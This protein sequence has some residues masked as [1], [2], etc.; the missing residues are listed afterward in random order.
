M[1]DRMVFVILVRQV[2]RTI[3]YDRYNWNFFE[4]DFW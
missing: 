2:E 4:T 3:R 1:R